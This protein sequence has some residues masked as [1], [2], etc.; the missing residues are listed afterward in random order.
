MRA[1]NTQRT[2]AQSHTS[3]SIHVCEDNALAHRMR[4]KDE[5]LLT[6]F[7]RMHSS[8]KQCTDASIGA[9]RRLPSRTLLQGCIH[10]I[11]ASSSL[12]LSSLDLS[13]TKSL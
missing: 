10:G 4:Q 2:P 5:D 1:E 6:H 8:R 3:P 11:T 7:A 9:E 13:D 12:L